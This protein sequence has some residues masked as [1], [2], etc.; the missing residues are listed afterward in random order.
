[1]ISL[2]LQYFSLPAL[3][4]PAFSSSFCTPFSRNSVSLSLIGSSTHFRS[5]ALI[6]VTLTFTLSSASSSS[7]SGPEI[8]K[9]TKLFMTWQKTMQSGE[10]NYTKHFKTKYLKYVNST[11]STLSLLVSKS[12]NICEHFS[13]RRFDC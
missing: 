6:R 4:I 1:M 9:Q 2:Y 11:F 12:T 5:P 7:I 3:P 13:S 10:N 8:N